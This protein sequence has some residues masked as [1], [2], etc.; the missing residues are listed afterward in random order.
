M[1]L[2]N[3]NAN[4]SQNRSQNPNPNA[5][6][7]IQIPVYPKIDGKLKNSFAIH[8]KTIEDL[9]NYLH[10][11]YTYSNVRNPIVSA[12]LHNIVLKLFINDYYPNISKNIRTNSQTMPIIMGGIAFNMNVPNKLTKELTME[13]DDVDLKIYTTEISYNERKPENLAHVLSM[14]KYV[15]VIICM[16]MKQ[17]IAEMVSYS[18]NIFEP[19]DTGN[20]T[21]KQSGGNNKEKKSKKKYDKKYDHHDYKQKSPKTLIKKRQRRFGIM[22]PSKIKFIVKNKNTKDDI[23]DMHYDITYLSFEETYN[24]LM[25]KI[26]D[27][28]I[29]ITTKIIYAIDY[30]KPYKPPYSNKNIT[31]SDVKVIYPSIANPSF[32]SYYLMKSMQS[33][34]SIHLDT[35]I[36]SNLAISDILDIKS[37]I[38]LTLNN[39]KYVSIKSLLVD[40]IYMLKFAELLVIENSNSGKIIVPV[41]CIYKYYKYMIKFVRLHVIRR[42]YL[43]TL[44][45][46]M[47]S[48]KKL[49]KYVDEYLKKKTSQDGELLPINIQY[50][51]I[52]SD[53]HQDF[54]INKSMLKQF[55]PLREIVSDYENTVYFIKQSCSLFKKLD[56]NN[57]NFGKS[58]ESIS[59]QLA[60]RDMKGMGVGGGVNDGLNGGLNGGVNGGVNDGLNG[61]GRKKKNKYPDIIL[62]EGYDFDDTEL[63]S[64][65]K[66]S[67]NKTQNENKQILILD[68][69]HKMVKKE[70]S[71]LNKLSKTIKN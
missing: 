12:Q 23:P 3:K 8:H 64:N 22:Q 52:I 70:I 19:I 2:L 48:A 34:Q 13:T 38:K 26:N 41:D 5:N 61:G 28:D 9:H 69:V 50:K 30:I 57:Y 62:H 33:M 18:S 68:K 44:H 6:A 51:K 47:E 27:P 16:Y 17:I 4:R 31:F 58:I 21:K 15:N 39:C 59:I 66:T 53:F 63:D 55:E 35:L 20:L 10:D 65:N 25:E 29:L 11:I 45:G 7:P 56:D 32:Y 46:F 36:K 42:F 60:D 24:L 67:N 1:E 40:V 14:F 54:F 37:F 49:W 71:F 43:G